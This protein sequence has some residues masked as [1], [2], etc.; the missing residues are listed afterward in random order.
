M[1][2]V[3]AHIERLRA[4]LSSWTER[5]RAVASILKGPRVTVVVHA[6]SYGSPEEFE[7]DDLS[8]AVHGAEGLVDSGLYAVNAISVG[9]AVLSDDECDE[10]LRGGSS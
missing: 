7:Y 4:E 8:R 10:L 6:V 9:G 3:E 5:H 1:R 2:R